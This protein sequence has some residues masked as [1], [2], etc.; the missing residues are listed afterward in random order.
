MLGFN[1]DGNKGSS[2]PAAVV[3]VAVV[4]RV[5]LEIVPKA[6]NDEVCDSVIRDDS[7]AT[8]EVL[9]ITSF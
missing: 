2:S 3:V 1:E 9:S 7:M 4:E 6:D 5:V 8:D